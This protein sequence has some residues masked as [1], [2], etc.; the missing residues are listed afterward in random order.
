[1][2]DIQ[3]GSQIDNREFP[4]SVNIMKQIIPIEVVEQ[5]IFMI[6]GHKVMIDRDLANLYGV[7]TRVLNQAVRRNI[8]RFPEDFMFYLTAI[9]NT[10]EEFKNHVV[11]N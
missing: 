3:T 9:K 5:K 7:E 10:I 6:R 2:S 8:D 1:M 11:K 4:Q